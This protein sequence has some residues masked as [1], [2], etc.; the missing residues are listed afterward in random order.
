MATALDYDSCEMLVFKCNT[1]LVDTYVVIG[2]PKVLIGCDCFDEN[3]FI[4][5]GKVKKM[6]GHMRLI[7][8]LNLQVN[9]AKTDERVLTLTVTKK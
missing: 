1:C 8:N 9:V 3:D 7:E 5:V 4:V 6:D 2:N